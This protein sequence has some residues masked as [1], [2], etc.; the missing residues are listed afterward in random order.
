MG[1]TELEVEVTVASANELQ[2]VWIEARPGIRPGRRL[3]LD[4][5]SEAHRWWRIT[6]VGQIRLREAEVGFEL[7]H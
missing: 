4:H 3:R 6:E 7:A 5:P 2:H 1:Y